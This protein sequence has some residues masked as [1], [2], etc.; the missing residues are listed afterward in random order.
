MVGVVLHLSKFFGRPPKV[1]QCLFR[2]TLATC[3]KLPMSLIEVPY[4]LLC[5]SNS[6]EIQPLLC[7][8]AT[9]VV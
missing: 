6:L 4:T 5:A 2:P 7:F 8:L 9:P 1:M 3:L